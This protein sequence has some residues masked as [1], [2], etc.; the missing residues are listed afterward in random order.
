MPPLHTHRLKY[1][2]FDLT[3]VAVAVVAACLGG[4]APRGTAP[5]PAPTR[6]VGES[7]GS[8]SEQGVAVGGGARDDATEEDARFARN[9][10]DRRELR[11]HHVA[12]LDERAQLR[13][14]LAAAPWRGA[15]EEEEIVEALTLALDD[16]ET[17]LAEAVLNA[18]VLELER[19]SWPVRDAL[20]ELRAGLD[21]VGALEGAAR[22]QRYLKAGAA[23][24]DT[25]EAKMQDCRALDAALRERGGDLEDGYRRIFRH[26]EKLYEDLDRLVRGVAETKRTARSVRDA[27]LRLTDEPEVSSEDWSLVG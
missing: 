14:E 15:E 3:V 10:R 6:V 18:D 11:R 16:V 21:G 20:R 9:R 17:I 23:R 8:G 2:L 4:R 13:D 22:V 24:L 12:A 7:L 27:L 19:L 1:A 25:F 5:L 26:V